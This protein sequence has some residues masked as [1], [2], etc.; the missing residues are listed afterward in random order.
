MYSHINIHFCSEPTANILST[1]AKNISNFKKNSVV[2]RIKK[3][4]YSCIGYHPIDH[5]MCIL[6]TEL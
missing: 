2:S 3:I 4:Q 6:P 1:I 5:S